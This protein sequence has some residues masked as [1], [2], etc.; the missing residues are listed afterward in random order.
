MKFSKDKPEEI[1]SILAEGVEMVGELSF[2]HGLRV[3]GV[4]K[5]KVRSEAF[6]VIG[7]KGKVDAEVVI[8][9]ISING[10]FRGVVRA[11]ERVEVHK[12]GRVYGEIYTPCLII[13]AGALFE[14]KC[15]MSE[16]VQAVQ[17]QKTGAEPAG[18]SSTTA[19]SSKSAG[20]ERIKSL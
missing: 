20:E 6:L 3:D 8:R 2:A 13:E 15:N 10:E 4:V 17:A 7:P 14:G 19:A 18:A 16:Q 5:G 11:T 9:R 12:E 1:A